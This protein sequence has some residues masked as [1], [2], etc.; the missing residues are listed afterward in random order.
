MYVWS[1]VLYGELSMY[2]AAQVAVPRLFASRAA[3]SWRRLFEQ[4]A[5]QK[6]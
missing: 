2:A 4:L 6:Q 1:I 5:E 3:V